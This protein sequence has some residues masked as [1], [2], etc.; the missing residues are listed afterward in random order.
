MLNIKNLLS[1]ILFILIS[2]IVGL[3]ICE[4]ALRVIHKFSYNYDIEMWKYAKKLKTKDENPKIGHTHI[5]NKSESLQGVKISINNYGQ[6][7]IDLNN[8][9]I[10]EYDRSFL[11]L[12]SSV[13]LGWGVKQK[14]IFTNILNEISNGNNKNW[15]FVNGGI[16]NYNTERY[17]N[18]YLENWKELKFSDIIIHFFVN[19][20]EVIKESRTN[21]F[22]THTHLGVIVWK[23]VNTYKSSFSKDNLDDYY[24]KRYKEDYEGFQTTLRELERL[25]NHCQKENIKCHIVLMPDIH[26]LNPYNLKFINEKMFFV[27]KKLDLPF[28]DLLKVFKNIDEKKIWNKYQDPHPNDFGHELMAKEI[29]NYLTK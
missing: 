2:V 19:D 26:Q 9:I 15:I 27:S 12:G 11:I 4:T 20:T 21:F 3:I 5:K 13:A 28:L 22:T 29:Y 8:S 18:N 1:K 17:V 25:K 10:K 14:N 23:L 24:K 16:G 7:D 6:R